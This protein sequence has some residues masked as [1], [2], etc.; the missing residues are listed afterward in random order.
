M[1]LCARF[2]GLSATVYNL[3]ETVEIA[4]E[5]IERCGMADRVEAVPGDW[6]EDEFGRDPL[7]RRAR[8]DPDFP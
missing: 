7:R 5:V 4:R 3:P 6:R 8:S 2:E 1:A